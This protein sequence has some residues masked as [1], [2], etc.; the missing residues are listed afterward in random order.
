MEVGLIP[1]DFVLDGDPA[2]PPQQGTEPPIFGPCLL[3]QNGTWH[4]GGPESRPHCSRWGPSSPHKKGRRAPNFRPISVV[5][6]GWMHQYAT[7]YG[8]RPQS[9]QLCA[10]WGHSP[11]PKKGAEPP[12]F[13]PCLLCQTA[14]WIKMPLGTDVGL[15][16]GDI[17]LDG[18][19]SCPPKRVQAP[20]CDPCVFWPNGCMYQDTVWYGGRPQLR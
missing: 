20:I 8:G 17:V 4:G 14:G 1:G 12:N 3:W 18:G 5:A 10:R 6:N 7:W 13:R 15:G 2:L 16:P 9:R 11:L 19:P